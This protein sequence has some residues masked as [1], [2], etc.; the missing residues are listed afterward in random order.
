[1]G[2]QE[3]RGIAIKQGDTFE[4]IARREYNGHGEY[5]AALADF[6]RNDRFTSDALK[7]GK[8][9]PG[10]TILIP[11]EVDLRTRALS[12]GSL[13]DPGAFRVVAPQTT[14]PTAY[15]VTAPAGETLYAIAGKVFGNAERWMDIAKANPSIE[16]LN[17]VP[18]GKFLA[19]PVDAKVP[20]ENRP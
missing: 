10:D 6:N 11:P 18:A 17:P 5:A 16:P 12:R 4:S 15:K 19:M 13:V 2:Y 14:P 3:V 7:T 8:L 9:V 1:M 20:P